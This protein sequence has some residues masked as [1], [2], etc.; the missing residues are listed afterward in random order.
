MNKDRYHPLSV[1]LHWL[2]FLLFV[3]ALAVIEYRGDLPKGDPWRDTLRTI[4]M[5]AGQFVLLLVTLRVLTR[6]RYGVPAELAAP[7]W[8]RLGVT[9]MHL[10]L[11]VIMFA[12]PLSG[13][14]FTQ[15]G[16]RDVVFFS[17]TL[18]PL[19]APNPDLR[20][21]IRAVHEFMGNAVYYLVGLHI[22][23]ALF[24]QFVRKDR[25]FRRMSWRSKND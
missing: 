6:W 7:Q 17:W 23:G 3:V 24:H 20:G 25:I 2:I 22:A 15:A 21:P 16:G 10:L 5:H 9:A 4:H 19:I 13:I 14:L 12:L 11:Y 8:Q 18:P 1:L